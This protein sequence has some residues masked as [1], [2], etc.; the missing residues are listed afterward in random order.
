M[1]LK[2]NKNYETEF[3]YSEHSSGLVEVENVLDEVE[4]YEDMI[5][6]INSLQEEQGIDNILLSYISG[7]S[8]YSIAKI[9]NFESIPKEFTLIRLFSCLGVELSKDDIK[10]LMILKCKKLNS[11]D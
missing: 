2:G 5:S 10:K 7:V 11:I 9:K 8:R 3:T 6:K 1:D 4:S